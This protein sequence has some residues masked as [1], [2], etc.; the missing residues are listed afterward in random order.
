[1][2]AYNLICT[3]YDGFLQEKDESVW[4]VELS[5]ETRVY[6]DDGRYGVTDKAW[7]RLREY[8]KTTHSTISKLFIKFRSHIELVVER[9]ENTIGW[10]FGRAA[11]CWVGCP[12]TNYMIV[13]AV[14]QSDTILARTTKWRVPEII[15]DVEEDRD[16]SDYLDN[17]IWE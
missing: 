11:G 6:C 12:T 15:K 16:P 4:I 2:S 8:I 3:S 7:D 10:Y 5:D 14:Q 1:M 13:G 17:I 9:D